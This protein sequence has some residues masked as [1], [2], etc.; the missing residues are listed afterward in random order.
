MW[1][2]E[3]RR[4]VDFS[5][6]SA[7]GPRNADETIRASG[8]SPNT[9]LCSFLGRWCIVQ[10]SRNSKTVDVDTG[11]F[12][13]FPAGAWDGSYIISYA[14]PSNTKKAK[15]HCVRFGLFVRP[16][17]RVSS[18]TLPSPVKGSPRLLTEMSWVALEASIPQKG[19]IPTSSSLPT[20]LSLCS[21][22]TFRCGGL[23]TYVR[24]ESPVSFQPCQ[25]SVPVP[26]PLPLRFRPDTI[27]ASK[28]RTQFLPPT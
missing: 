9:F 25:A 17:R 16:C 20:S 18:C 1:K 12:K 5:R 22:I 4:A 27:A 3:T 10:I 2:I 6:F 28:R 24:F 13:L 11:R 19:L 26:L 21:E 15:T 14:C 7:G 8:N 23:D